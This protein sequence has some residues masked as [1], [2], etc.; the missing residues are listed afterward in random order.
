[1]WVM[2]EYTRCPHI[3]QV[4]GVDRPQLNNNNDKLLSVKHREDGSSD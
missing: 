1:M 4:E 3:L 2:R